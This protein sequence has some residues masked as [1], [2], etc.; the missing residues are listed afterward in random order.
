MNFVGSVAGYYLYTYP[1]L[2]DKIDF[3]FEYFP[4]FE[5]ADI[6]TDYNNSKVLMAVKL[7]GFE[8]I[9]NKY[10]QYLELHFGYYVREHT[11]G[12]KDRNLYV[13]FGINLSK[14]FNDLSMEKASTFTRYFQVPYTYV[15][16]V[17]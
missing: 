2:S 17:K 14:I 10:L 5:K 15:E 12:H 7:D 11:P 4:R 3:R 8:S 16:A 1:E 9:T 6:F 13:G